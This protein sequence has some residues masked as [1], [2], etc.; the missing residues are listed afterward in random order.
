MF[1]LVTHRWSARTESDASKRIIRLMLDA[2]HGKIGRPW[3]RLLTLWQNPREAE[4]IAC[5]EATERRSLE[6]VF[7]RVK[8]L[9]T[10]IKHVRQL[11]PPH[12]QGY[13]VMTITTDPDWQHGLKVAGTRLLSRGPARKRSYG[14]PSARPRVPVLTQGATLPKANASSR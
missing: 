12:V 1:F 10:E 11:Y 14:S 2:H 13:N 6:R 7:K 9:T 5:W 4:V 3:P 8:P